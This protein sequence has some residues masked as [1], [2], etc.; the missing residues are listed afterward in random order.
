MSMYVGNAD[1]RDGFLRYHEI[2]SGDENELYIYNLS[3][4]NVAE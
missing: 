2:S 1:K 4:I 3:G